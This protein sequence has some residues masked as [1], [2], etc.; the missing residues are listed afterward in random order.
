MLKKLGSMEVYYF[1]AKSHDRQV[2]DCIVYDNNIVDTQMLE[3]LTVDRQ[4]KWH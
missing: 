2:P 4:N 1:V 3:N